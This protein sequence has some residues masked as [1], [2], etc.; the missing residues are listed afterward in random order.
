MKPYFR[1]FKFTGL[2]L[3]LIC[4]CGRVHTQKINLTA[5]TVETVKKAPKDFPG[6]RNG[7]KMKFSIRWLGLEVGTGELWVKGI[8]QVRGR[9][10]Y[11][12]V[13]NV[14][15]NSVIDIV[16]PVRD[17]HQTYIDVEKLHS[18]RY[19]KKLSEGRYQAD[20]SMDFDQAKH[21]ATYTAKKS[22]EQK[23]MMIP[24]D[25]QDQ[26]S[27][28]F[29]LR[30]QA[31]GPG[32]ILKVP[33]SADEKNWTAEIKVLKFEQLKLDNVGTFNA[34]EI[35]P[36]VKFQGA[37]IHM[38]KVRGWLSADEKRLPLMMKT[39]IPVLGT[40]SAVLIQSE[41]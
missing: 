29:W 21:I 5:E 10:A 31:M 20:E 37:F 18:L 14:R 41:G 17:E 1:F 38:G 3:L 13:F 11:H 22:G 28:G 7:E 12:V 24:K 27:C 36:M 40:V 4:G 33:I 23:Q 2:A 25:V 30:R 15:S 26:L 8:E 9:D 35:E 32:E 6:I 34:F 19:E 39:K 16:Y